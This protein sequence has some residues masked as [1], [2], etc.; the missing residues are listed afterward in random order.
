MRRIVIGLVAHVDSG[1][2]TL[3][4][5]LLY[6]T[7]QIREAGHVDNGNAFLDT[8]ALEKERGITIFAK[9]AALPLSPEYEATLLDTPGHVDFSAEMERTLQVLD[10]A[11]LVISGADGV[12]SHTTTLWSL[13]EK[14]KVPVFLFINKMDQKRLPE[15]ELLKDLQEK[16]SAGCVAFP[17][18]GEA[19]DAAFYEQAAMSDDEALDEFLETEKLSEET[20]IRLARERKIFPCY[21]GSALRREGI[22]NLLGGLTRYTEGLQEDD[23]TEAFGARVFKIGKGAKGERLTYMKITS[24]SLSVKQSIETGEDLVEKIDGIRLYNGDRFVPIA[25]AEKGMVVAVTGPDATYSGQGL[26]NETG[27]TVPILEPVIT[28]ELI[29]PDGQDAM[30]WYPKLKPLEEELCELHMVW[31]EKSHSIML[32]L[33]GEVQTDVLKHLIKE[34]Y[35]IS[36]TFGAGRIAYKETI[37]DVTEGVGHYEPL[38][39]Y[40][41]VH[42]LMR[43]LPRGSGIVYDTD[44]S[45]DELDRNWQRLILTNLKEKEHPGVLVGAPIT[46]ME[47]TLASGR[48]H[49]KHTEGGDFRQAVYRAVRQG[50]MKAENLL[51]EPWFSFCIAVPADSIGRAMSDL[52]RLYA[53]T[54]PPMQEGDR[55]ILTGRGPVATLNTY[56]KELAAYTGGQGTMTALFDGYEPCHDAEAVVEATGYDP[57]ADTD[58]PVGSIFCAHGSGFY[59]NWDR[60]EDYMHLPLRDLAQEEEDTETDMVLKGMRR[61]GSGEKELSIGREEIDSIIQKTSHANAGRTRPGYSHRKDASVTRMKTTN[62]FSDGPDGTAYKEKP[63]K[64]RKSY[65]LVD[66]YNVIFAWKELKELADVNIDS[67]RDKLADILCNYQAIKGCELILVFDAY[68]LQNHAEEVLS[69]HNIR[70]VYTKTA[71]TADRYIE[72]FAHEKASDC[73]VTVVTSDGMEQIIIRGSGALLISSREFEKEVAEANRQ[74][75]ETGK[76]VLF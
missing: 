29:L 33:M 31:D 38:R 7:G 40:A 19:P 69:F 73:L 49:L 35:D 30:Q 66:G 6:E 62:Y 59:V 3:S 54:D 47:I 4:E 67:A 53:K 14:Y 11:I 68:R 20:L 45:E 43:P 26:G 17:K 56:P 10:C 15:E 75:M 1:K 23:G 36:V 52:D 44:V 58:N 57:E 41:E 34:R 64:P 55:M 25:K 70:I 65:L 74:I 60:V 50:L 22:R 13:L 71:E 2:T 12:Q 48:A 18:E 8:Y 72:K 37:L 5:S 32:K 42:L 9:Q 16:L 51:L 24:G 61:S 21:F 28:Y 76:R 46:D 63:A 39:H 27:R